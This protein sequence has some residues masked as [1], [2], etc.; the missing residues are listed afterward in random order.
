V[1]S[2]SQSLDLRGQQ[3]YAQRFGHPPAFFLVEPLF[4]AVF[5]AALPEL[6]DL[7]GGWTSLIGG[8]AC[9]R[10][11]ALAGGRTGAQ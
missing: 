7:G 1:A 8:C 6:S 3:R 4:L 10:T 9:D 11:A 5:L 2:P